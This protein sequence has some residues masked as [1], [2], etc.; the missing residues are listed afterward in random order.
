MRRR[1]WFLAGFGLMVAVVGGLSDA[2]GGVALG[3]I[4]VVVGLSSWVVFSGSSIHLIQT[5][6]SDR[7]EDSGRPAVSHAETVSPDV[8]V[9]R[10]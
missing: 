6:E 3:S 2:R 9:P 1:N 4:A 8:Q 5:P 7:D 10:I